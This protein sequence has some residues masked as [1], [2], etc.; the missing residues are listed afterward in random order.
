MTQFSQINYLNMVDYI[1]MMLLEQHR[2]HASNHGII[3]NFKNYG[4]GFLFEKEMK[5]LKD[6]MNKPE[7]PLVLNSWWCKSIY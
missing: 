2:T 1:L 7:R 3:D 5:Y 6:V 4:I